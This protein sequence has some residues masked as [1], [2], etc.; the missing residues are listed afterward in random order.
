[1][2]LFS[3]LLVPASALVLLLA[4]NQDPLP[5]SKPPPSSGTGNKPLVRPEP[6]VTPSEGAAKEIARTTKAM[7]GLWILKQLEWPHLDGV[8]SEFRGYCMVSDNHLSFEVHIGLR[9]PDG[10]LRS[11]MMDSG[12]WRFD[13]GEANRTVMTLLIGSFVD[14]DDRVAFREADTQVRYE[15][16]AM[17]DTMV[18]RKEDGQRL[19]FE[20][21][22]DGGLARTDIFGRPIP[23]PKESEAKEG[24]PKKEPPK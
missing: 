20:R 2:R 22:L 12:L 19:S 21:I 6:R 8:S 23:E 7:Q 11:V 16:I 17:G 14:K 13:V 15:V 4:A 18:W 9:T 5:P 1:M 10:K 24:E 3:I